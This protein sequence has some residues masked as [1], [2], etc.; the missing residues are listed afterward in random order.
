[1]IDNV[2]TF[3]EKLFGLL[4]QD[5]FR[6]FIDDLAENIQAQYW[7]GVLNYF[8]PLKEMLAIASVWIVAVGGYIVVRT[9]IRKITN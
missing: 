2:T 9:F 7:V 6:P 1:M 8:I 5:P 3:I 4:P